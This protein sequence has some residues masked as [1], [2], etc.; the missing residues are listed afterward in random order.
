M[1][2]VFGQ[3][4]KEAYYML[5]G[6]VFLL[7]HL[8]DALVAI[9]NFRRF[10][11]IA[12]CSVIIMFSVPSLPV[13][14]QTI[15]VMLFPNDLDDGIFRLFYLWHY[16]VCLLYSVYFQCIPTVTVSIGIEILRIPLSNI[17]G[18]L[19]ALCIV[20]IPAC[21]ILQSLSLYYM[22]L[23]DFQNHWV[24]PDSRSRVWYGPD[25]NLQVSEINS[26]RLLCLPISFS[27]DIRVSIYFR[28]VASPSRRS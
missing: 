8:V 18:L 1:S 6:Q 19:A 10:T 2:L 4:W 22:R 28:T 25:S 16:I 11:P 24:Y 23:F 5:K 17:C 21:S 3:S 26:W 12:Q 20:F 14:G 13:L 15:L 27:I 9:P 7:T